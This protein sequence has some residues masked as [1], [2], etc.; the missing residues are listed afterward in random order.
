MQL[1]DCTLLH[2]DQH[3]SR[4]GHQA[5]DLTLLEELTYDTARCTQ[6]ILGN[7]DNDAKF[8]YDRVMAKFSS[9]LGLAHGIS[10]ALIKL[11]TN[12]LQQAKYYIRNSKKTK[13]L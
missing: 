12:T 2:P 4:P 5:N 9:L 11:N 13:L 10:L 7:F 6:T 1:E 3:G 8:C